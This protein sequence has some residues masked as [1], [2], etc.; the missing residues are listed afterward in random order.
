MCKIH[1]TIYLLLPLPVTAAI[2]SL[3]ISFFS[4]KDRKAKKCSL[5]NYQETNKCDILKTL[6]WWKTY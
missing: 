4:L 5:S 2:N 1:K 3:F 6:P